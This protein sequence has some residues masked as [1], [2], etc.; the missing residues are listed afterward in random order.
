MS[1]R[2]WPHRHQ[3]T[4][5][6]KIHTVHK[7]IQNMVWV[8]GDFEALLP[9][10][11]LKDF[12]EWTWR[13]HAYTFTSPLDYILELGEVHVLLIQEQTESTWLAQCSWES[14]QISKYSWGHLFHSLLMDKDWAV[15]AHRPWIKHH[16]LC[17]FVFLHLNKVFLLTPPDTVLILVS[18][19]FLQ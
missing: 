15:I 16:L 14:K 2:N 7:H 19:H 8:W 3:E 6:Y 9:Q 10:C 5:L 13:L 12:L 1:Q 11:S 4:V 18:C 17:F